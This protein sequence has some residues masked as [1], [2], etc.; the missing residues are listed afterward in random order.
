MNGVISYSLYIVLL[1]KEFDYFDIICIFAER[2]ISII[3][4]QNLKE[5]T[6]NH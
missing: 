3:A 6:I 4:I 1:P 5:Q 2:N